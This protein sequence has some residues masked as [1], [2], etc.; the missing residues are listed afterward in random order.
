MLTYGPILPG[1]VLGFVVGTFGEYWV[2]RAMHRGLVLPRRHGDHHREG[3][4]QGAI[5]EFRDY[6]GGSVLAAVT[7]VPLD[8]F[9]FSGGALAAGLVSGLLIHAVFAAWCHQAQH[10]D[11]RLLP[12]QSETP[13]HFVHHR[14]AQARHNFGISVD[15]WDR[16][17]GTYK[18]E[19]NW[20]TMIHA[21]PRAWWQID[22]F[23]TR[24]RAQ[25]R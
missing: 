23:D 18:A 7:F 10:D 15:W 6:I 24:P 8:Y 4:G 14:W 2:H 22:W 3:V 11:P 12:W 25:T 9:Y 5:K 1:I 17:F 21:P 20:R 19:P 13:V 16:A